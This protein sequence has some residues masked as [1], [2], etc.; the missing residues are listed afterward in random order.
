MEGFVQYITSTK[1]AQ[2]QRLRSL[3]DA[4]AR[5]DT[6]LFLVEGWNLLQEAIR[7]ACVD[8][9]VVDEAKKHVLSDVLP[10]QLQANVLYAPSFVL[11]HICQTKT[12]QGVAASVYLPKPIQT[13]SIQ[14][15]V[16]ALDGVQD[17]GNVGTMIRT[18]EAAGFSA[19][20][21]SSDSADPYAPKTVRAT[22]GS[23]F[24]MPVLR[25]DLLHFLTDL[26]L[27]GT[28]IIS[29]EVNGAPIQSLNIS[30]PFALV[31][32]NEGNG[33]QENIAELSNH[34]IALPM[35][36]KVESLNAAVAAGIFMYA[37][38][39]LKPDPPQ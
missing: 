36:G 25:G 4:K 32:G 20:L 21:L 15:K 1:N 11:A 39:I 16:L 33:I 35:C 12:P 29:T 9:I 8:V 31:I 10:N 17:P 22:M 19:V 3:Q 23:I 26:Q 6:S 30:K 14:G 18:A 28:I 34:R 2:I 27:N 38:T 7:Y 5:A 24:R 13:E 37:L